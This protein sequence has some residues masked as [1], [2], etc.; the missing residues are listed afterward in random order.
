MKVL[1][2]FAV[3]MS[4]LLLFAACTPGGE[5]PEEPTE[6]P[7]ESGS[8]D[9]SEADLWLEVS[10][11]KM[12]VGGK[13]TAFIE[14]LKAAG[15]EAD[16]VDSISS[17]MFD[18]KDNTYHFSFGDVFTFPLTTDDNTVDEIYGSDESVKTRGGLG[19]GSSIEEIIAVFGE[20]YYMDGANLMI[21]NAE[22]D[23]AK[24]ESLPKLY[25]Y[26]ENNV[27]TGVGLVAN[28]YH[29]AG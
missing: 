24:N 9:F 2:I 17:C 5:N 8:T 11:V 23:A 27:A 22:A 18:G 21:Y 14:A 6:A 28:L 7:A 13:E 4:M 29:V 25:F 3:I 20:G 10:G 12:E 15:V 16:S 26:I 1:K 19:V